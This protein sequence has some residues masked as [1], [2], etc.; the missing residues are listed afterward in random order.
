M[1]KVKYVPIPLDMAE[2]IEELSD[3]EIGLVVRAYLQYGRSGE[4]A[5]MPR[6]IKY[7]YNALVRELDRA[8]DGYEKKIAAGKSGGR[9]RPK[10]EPS[11]EIQQ[12]ESAQLNPEP[13]QK[14]KSHTPAPFISDEEA[15]E[16]QQGT[17]EVLDE[18][19]RQGFPDT[20]ATM[21]TLNQL[22]ADNGTEEVL[23]C[24]KIAGEAGKPNIRYLKGV[25]NGRAKE[26]QEEERQARID[27]EKYPVVSSADY[28]YKPPSVTFGEVFKKYAKQRALE[29]PEERV[30]LEELAGRFS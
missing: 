2:D 17:N 13:E 23:E 5:E 26:R 21:E 20:T 30:K 1:A 3:E 22:V 28:D 8:S 11:E 4:T 29:H 12:P 9:G 6:T 18:A 27:A 15:A 16:I 25:I 24:V 10:K 19:K 7:L 14:P